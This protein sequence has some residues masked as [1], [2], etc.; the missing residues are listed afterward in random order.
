MNP[1]A[2]RAVIRNVG[3]WA[4]AQANEAMVNP[5]APMT[6]RFFRPNLSPSRPP[7]TRATAKASVYAPTT[8]CTVLLPPP[9]AR[10]IGVAARLTIVAS[11]R[12]MISAHRMMPRTSQRQRYGCE[13]DS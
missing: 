1:C 8:H 5:A 6:K 2:T 11:S 4:T 12:S 13:A 10:S 3:S 9:R 7:T